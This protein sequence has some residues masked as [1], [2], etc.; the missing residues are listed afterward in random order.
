MWQNSFKNEITKF[1]LYETA[2]VVL[3]ELKRLNIPVKRFKTIGSRYES[4]EAHTPICRTFLGSIINP[5]I[6]SKQIVV[7]KGETKPVAALLH[8]AGHLAQDTTANIARLTFDKSNKFIY[9]LRGEIGAN[10]Q[11]AKMLTKYSP[12]PRVMIKKYNKAVTPGL[13]T[14]KFGL[15]TRDVTNVPVKL[16]KVIQKILKKPTINAAEVAT[17]KSIE[18]KFGGKVSGLLIPMHTRKILN[19]TAVADYI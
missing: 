11:V 16:N 12:N 4:E 10:M 13:Q 1:A 3:K 5:K 6:R 15:R 2:K 18:R 9:E 14:Y 8:E 7:T 19:E 17:V